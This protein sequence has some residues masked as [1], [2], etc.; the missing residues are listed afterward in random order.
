MDRKHEQSLNRAILYALHYGISKERLVTVLGQQRPG[1][2]A[3][4]A[5]EE[6]DKVIA[7]NKLAKEYY[8]RW[9]RP[10]S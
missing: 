9:R 3:E 5:L 2:T 4:Q 10:S 8:D 6:L 1:M 7:S